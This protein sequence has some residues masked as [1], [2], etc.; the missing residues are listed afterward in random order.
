MDKIEFRAVIKLLIN[1]PVHKS[2]VAMTALHSCGLQMPN[3]PPYSPD[4]A[5]PDYLFPNMKKE[6][7]GKKF[8]DDE[9]VKSAI[10]AYFESKDKTFFSQDI[11]KLIERSEKCI[12]VKGEYI[13]KE[14]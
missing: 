13:E 5:P 3:H 11:N 9:E 14:K 2:N 1:V 7:R 10:S 12:R 6:L 4:L 8:T